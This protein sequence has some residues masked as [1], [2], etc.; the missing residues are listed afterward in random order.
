MPYVVIGDS[1][2]VTYS[3]DGTHQITGPSQISGSVSVSNFPHITSVITSSAAISL[4]L[5]GCYVLSS[6]SGAVTATVPDPGRIPGAVFIFRCGSAHAHLVTGSVNGFQSFVISPGITA[7]GAAGS[8]VALPAVQNSSVVL[9]SDGFH[10][11][12]SAAS[13]S[14]TL[15]QS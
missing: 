5:G 10:Y 15:A 4:A 14:C 9:V 6:S 12:V 2:A 7:T 1:G 8:R 13:G 3:G 11:I